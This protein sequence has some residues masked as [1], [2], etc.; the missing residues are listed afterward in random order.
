MTHQKPYTWVAML[1]IEFALTPS[2]V[3]SI[4]LHHGGWIYRHD[5]R[6]YDLNSCWLMKPR[7]NCMGDTRRPLAAEWWYVPD[8]TAPENTWRDLLIANT[9]TDVN[10]HA[11]HTGLRGAIRACERYQQ[12]ESKPAK[13]PINGK[14]MINLLFAGDSHLRQMFEAMACRWRDF[15]T[16]G[17]LVTGPLDR[18]AMSNRVLGKRGKMKRF[19]NR[20]DTI[21]S[22]IEQIQRPDNAPNAMNPP[23]HYSLDSSSYYKGGQFPPKQ[24]PAE[25]MCTDD[26]ARIEYLDTL[27]IYYIFRSYAYEGELETVLRDY[28]GVDPQDIDIVVH[29]ENQNLDIKWSS[30]NRSP[31]FLDFSDVRGIL[32]KQLQRDAGTAYGATNAKME[33]D[34]HPCLPGIPDD[35]IDVLFVALLTESEIITT[36]R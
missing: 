30:T 35:E 31:H 27:R 17:T 13:A 14:R 2:R 18:P 22:P 3:N 26:L 12:Q 10:D 24:E 25:E 8:L 1:A 34:G 28:L 36:A 6:D 19:L 5:R 11:E 15:V 32:Q 4:S 16:G 21:L 9:D 33:D 20:S 7:Y 23:C 29:N